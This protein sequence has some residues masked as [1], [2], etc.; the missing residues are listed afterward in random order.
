MAIVVNIYVEDSK[1]YGG[2][3]ETME[4]A[5]QWASNHSINKSEIE[6]RVEY[7]EEHLDDRE[8][9]FEALRAKRKWI[10][11]ATDWLFVS[12]FRVSTKFRKI[13]M[14]YRQYLRDLPKIIGKEGV[15]KLEEF[16]HYLRRKYPEEFMDGGDSDII[17]KHFYSKI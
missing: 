1:Q 17:L 4:E 12:D 15:I 8:A 2:S 9:K 10:L 16:Y 14:E 13:Y 6:H 11:D 3:F 7:I 5:E